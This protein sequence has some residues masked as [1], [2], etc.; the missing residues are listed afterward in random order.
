MKNRDSCLAFKMSSSVPHPQKNIENFILAQK[1]I[2]L[3]AVFETTARRCSDN[4]KL[5][6]RR[7]QQQTS[8]SISWLYDLRKT[9]FVTL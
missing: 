9:G 1:G 6:M 5:S 3:T 8:I 4:W 7:T 2:I